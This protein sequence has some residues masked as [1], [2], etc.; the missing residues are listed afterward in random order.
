MVQV[1]E[2]L[3]DVIIT[4]DSFVGS[5][6]PAA[7]ILISAGATRYSLLLLNHGMKRMKIVRQWILFELY[8][9]CLE[10]A[11]YENYINDLHILVNS[12]GHFV[13]VL[14]EMASACSFLPCVQSTS[15]C[16]QN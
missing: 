12:C 1:V 15:T 10:N 9:C 6:P 5:Y 3:N 14:A 7:F 13:F 4:L 8:P 11:L 16:Y 2:Y